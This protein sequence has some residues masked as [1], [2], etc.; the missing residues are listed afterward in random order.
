MSYSY[1]EAG[2]VRTREGAHLACVLDVSAF[3]DMTKPE[4]MN[5]EPTYIVDFVISKDKTRIGY[6]RYGAGPAL[7]LSNGAIGTTLSYHNLAK[8]LAS[9]FTVYV[10]ER[11]GR[12]LS[13]REYSPDHCIQRE[14]ED[15]EAIL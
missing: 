2:S 6:R 12:P 10:P 13:P 14:R 15:L 1:L 4:P 3:I 8:D 5:G 11:R 7:I 9:D